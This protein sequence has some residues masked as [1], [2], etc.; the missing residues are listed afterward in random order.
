MTKS[1]QE[2][3]GG[4]HPSR[5]SRDEHASVPLQ[6]PRLPSQNSAEIAPNITITMSQSLRGLEGMQKYRV[7]V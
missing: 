5:N 1:I 4:I 7:R 3:R 2:R 6:A